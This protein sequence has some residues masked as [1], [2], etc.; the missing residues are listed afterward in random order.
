MGLQG[1][2]QDA[3]GWE[4]GL[5][6]SFDGAIRRLLLSISNPR[7]CSFKLLR[8]LEIRERDTDE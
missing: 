1:L 4:L 8:L 5:L 6:C 3:M 2:M 7:G